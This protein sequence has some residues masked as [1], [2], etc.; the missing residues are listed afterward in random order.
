MNQYSK[1]T[2]PNRK[3][4]NSGYRRN[5]QSDG[6]QKIL[7]FYVLPFIVLNGLI[8]ILATARPKAT[9][10]VNNSS[11]YISTTMELKVKSLLP[12]KSINVK[13]AGDP[14][15]LTKIGPNTYT[16]T[17]KSNG[18]LI[19]NLISINKMVRNQKREVNELDDKQP[20]I[21]N[22]SIKD[23][24]LSFQISDGKSGMDYSSIYASTEDNPKILPESIN[25]GTGLVTFK[26]QD[27]LMLKVKDKADNELQVTINPKGECSDDETDQTE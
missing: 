4:L 16:A 9:I 27:N 26:Y 6:F 5:T 10:T 19:V 24:I 15:A 7:L 17:L 8:F 14:V 13:L 12:V 25:R 20:V 3:N 21:S 11:D 22:C 23:G 18:A 2:R 1:Q